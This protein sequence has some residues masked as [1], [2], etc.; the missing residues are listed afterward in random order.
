VSDSPADHDRSVIDDLLG[1]AER[2]S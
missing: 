2:D 1:D